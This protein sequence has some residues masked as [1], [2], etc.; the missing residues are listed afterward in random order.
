MPLHGLYSPCRNNQGWSKA[1]ASSPDRILKSPSEWQLPSNLS[2]P[3]SSQIFLA[4]SFISPEQTY[5]LTSSHAHHPR[6]KLKSWST[7][8]LGSTCRRLHTVYLDPASAIP[9]TLAI[10]I[11]ISPPSDAEGAFSTG[12]GHYYINH[13][14]ST[15]SG[16]QHSTPATSERWRP[17]SQLS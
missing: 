6:W 9:S 4:L 15:I 17:K 14:E 13:A 10:I 2:Q 12:G 5:T 16:S 1:G 3:S 7:L 11:P 8:V